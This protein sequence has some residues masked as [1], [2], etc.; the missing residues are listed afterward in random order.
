MVEVLWYHGVAIYCDS[1]VVHCGS[2]YV[3]Q[4]QYNQFP[5]VIALW[6][7]H[8]ALVKPIGNCVH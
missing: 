3:S 5:N 1:L 4:I 2:A 7:I 8:D 6:D